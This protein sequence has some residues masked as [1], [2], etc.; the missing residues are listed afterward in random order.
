MISAFGYQAYNPLEAIAR[1][2]CGEVYVI[3]GAVKAGNASTATKE[4]YETGLKL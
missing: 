3:G 1:S 2:H 4:G